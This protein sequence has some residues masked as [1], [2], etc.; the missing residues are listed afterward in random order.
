MVFTQN[1]QF[2]TNDEGA[3]THIW[4]GFLSLDVD[5]VIAAGGGSG[6][7]TLVHISLANG[8]TA[9]AA[10]GAAARIEKKD[11]DGLAITVVPEPGTALLFG[12]GLL[13]LASTGRPARND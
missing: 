7:A 8:L 4:S 12:L 11:I 2:E 13:G 9:F 3:G 1:G 6:Q 5:A 10:S